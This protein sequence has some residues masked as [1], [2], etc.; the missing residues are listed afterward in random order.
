G[1]AGTGFTTVIVQAKTLFGLFGTTI[2]FGT[3]DGVAPS[4][5]VV[6]TNTTGGGQLFVK[7]EIPGTINSPQFSIASGPGSFVSFDQFTVDTLW[8]D[9]GYAPDNAVPEPA[10]VGLFALCSLMALRRQRAGCAR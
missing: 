7:Y 2:G 3:I 10:T 9:S 8:S 1:P 6:G 5:I 4:D